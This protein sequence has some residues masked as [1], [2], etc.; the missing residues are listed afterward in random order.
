MII[1]KTLTEGNSVIGWLAVRIARSLATEE[2]LDLLVNFGFTY[3]KKVITQNSDAVAEVAV[4]LVRQKGEEV[5]DYL[6]KFLEKSDISRQRLVCAH[7]LEKIASFPE[8][9]DW[10]LPHVEVVNFAGF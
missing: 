3:D 9:R 4:A 2:A 1:P 5:V 8:F 10:L 7:A 6:V